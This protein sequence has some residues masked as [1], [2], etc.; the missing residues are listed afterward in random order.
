MPEPW[1]VMR[2]LKGT[3]FGCC[4]EKHGISIS[5]WTE[6][7]YTYGNRGPSNLPI[8]FNDRRDFWQMNQNFLRIDKAIDTS[9]NELQ[10]GGR[11][12]LI[13]PGTDARF[14]ISR[15]LLDNQNSQYPIDLF[16]AYIDTFLPN[17]G[18]QG[19]TLRI[20]KFATLVGY[21]LVQGAETPFVSRSY[22]FQYDPF[23]HT[24][25]LAITP[26]NDTWTVSNGLAL[27]SDNFIGA[28]AQLTYLGQV[29]W[30][31]KEGKTNALFNVVLTNPTFDAGE[32]F[33]FYN[34]Y[35]TVMTHK[36]SDKFTGVLDAT[37]SHMDGVPGVAAAAW[38]YG[39]AGYGIYNISDKLVATLRTELFDDNKGVRTGFPGLYTEVTFGV[40]WSPVR[41]LILR[42]AVRYDYNTQSRPWDGQKDIFTVAMDAIVRW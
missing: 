8:A 19:T 7:N 41:S 24:G 2:V 1:A 5:G 13:L 27:G 35:N 31:P 15:G 32:S 14:T 12:E 39:A 21:E 33:A 23:T 28:P 6:G 38:W 16:Q 18:P 10:W 34:C 26:L 11:A 9:K 17:L 25:G 30:A 4:M 40:A 22:I 36:F 42:P 3:Y 37:A 29:K 20:G